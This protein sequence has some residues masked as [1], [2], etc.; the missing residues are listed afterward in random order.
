MPFIVNCPSCGK[1]GTSTANTLL[2]QT[3]DTLIA[4]VKAAGPLRVS[5]SQPSAH[6]TVS[7]Q[8][9]APPPPAPLAPE[10]RLGPAQRNWEKADMTVV[11]S[12]GLG[13]VGAMLGAILSVVLMFAFVKFVGIEFPLMGL[14][15]GALTGYGARLMYKGTDMTLGVIA[16]V[17]ALFATGGTFLVL[18]GIFAI[19]N[20][21]SL[22][23]SVGIA[24]K[25][26]G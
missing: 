10:V 11:H 17:I 19:M 26:A 22:V 8:S 12:L 21:I 6:S 7:V 3:N 25:I 20:L 9:A 4:P 1:D 13:F 5:I 23:V 24:Y 2:A 16:G 15:I 18:F 14:A